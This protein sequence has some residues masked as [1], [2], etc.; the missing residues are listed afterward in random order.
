MSHDQIKRP[1]ARLQIPKWPAE[2]RM[3]KPREEEASP[4]TPGDKVPRF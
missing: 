4:G 3:R 2:A 1:R